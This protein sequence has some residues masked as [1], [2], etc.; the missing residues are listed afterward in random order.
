VEYS[1][2]AVLHDPGLAEAWVNLV[3]GYL[4]CARP[5]QADSVLKRALALFPE[6]ENLLRFSENLSR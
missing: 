1:R 2:Q 5:A 4:S 3:S 6:N